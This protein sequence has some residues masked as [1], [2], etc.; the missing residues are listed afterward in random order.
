ML[1]WPKKKD[2]S[3]DNKQLNIFEFKDELTKPHGAWDYF[4]KKSLFDI[5]NDVGYSA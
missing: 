2:G 3:F 5:L 1:D 4:D